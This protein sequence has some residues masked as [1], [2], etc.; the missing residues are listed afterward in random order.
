MSENKVPLKLKNKV[1]SFSDIF[2]S[3]PNWATY[4][5]FGKTGGART[6]L[7]AIVMLYN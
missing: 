2:W 7:G 5:V 4:G 1:T 3:E 6:M